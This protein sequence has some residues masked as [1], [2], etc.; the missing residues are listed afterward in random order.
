M[1]RALWGVLL[2]LLA[3][4]AAEADNTGAIKGYVKDPAGRIIPN[5]NLVLRSTENGRVA[6][7]AT[8]ANGFYQFL[9][10]APGKYEMTAE[11]PGFRKVDV[12][13]V[14]L[15]LD[16]IVSYDMQLEL[17]QVTQVVEVSGGVNGQ[18]RQALNAQLSSISSSIYTLK[19]G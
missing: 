13:D 18:E 10:L 17:G 6:K 3:V 12:K 1:R 2:L 16:Q 19:H 8:D 5:A 7:I 14:N 4:L 9:Q 15:L 11:V